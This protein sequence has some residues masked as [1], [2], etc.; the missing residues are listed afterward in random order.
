MVKIR[1]IFFLALSVLLSV[2]G[3]AEADDNSWIDRLDLTAGTTLSAGSEVPFWM[4]ANQ[5]GRI[6]DDRNSTVFTRIQMGKSVDGRKTFDW[7]Y[8]VDATLRSSGDSDALFTDLYAGLTYKNVRLTAGR[9][10]EFFGLAD[11][12]LTAGSEVYSRNAPTIPKVAVSTDGYV[13]LA[14]WLSFNA[15]FAHGWLGSE[16]QVPD[17]YL[18]EK[19]VY[20][21]FGSTVPDEGINFT[22]GIH[23]LAVWGGA[24]QPSS[25][26]DFLRI[27]VGSSGGSDATESDQANALGNHLGS[28]EYALQLK[29]YE[30]DWYLYAQTLFEDGSGLRFWYPGDILLGLSLINKEPEERIRRIN[31]EYLDTRSGGNN[32]TGESDNYF[33]NSTYGGW[34]YEGWGIGHPFIRFVEGAA[35]SYSPLNTLKGVNASVLMHYGERLNPL[36]RVAWVRGS[37]SF[38]APL[39]DSEKTT[40]ISLDLENTMHLPDGWSLGQ[41]LSCDAGTKT[42]PGFG[43]MLSVTKSWY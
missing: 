19:F 25:F 28:I 35:N 2:P 29:G 6:P 23:H 8:G 15:Y 5:Q 27:L 21:K 22:G 11:S 18:H 4:W 16:A 26:R 34:V 3:R 33:T 20:F 7:S 9:K 1:T 24:G 43:M 17:A 36:V 39:P 14:D 10:A 37:G 31:V 30:R 32:H 41:Q 12:L 42:E 13:D 40:L 38:G